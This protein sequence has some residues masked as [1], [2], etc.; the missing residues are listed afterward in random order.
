MVEPK[1]PL[2]IAATALLHERGD[3]F[4]RCRDK[5]V[6]SFD[7]EEIHD[8][9]VASR[10]LREGLQLFL[11]CYHGKLMGPLV[12]AFRKVT[13]L[14][15]EIRNTDEAASFFDGLMPE[16]DRICQHDVERLML[17]FRKKRQKELSRLRS[18]LLSLA[19]DSLRDRYRHAVNAL[20]LFSTPPNAVDLF[21]PLAEFAATALQDR[22]AKVLELAPKAAFCDAIEAQHQLRIA[23]KH[24]RYRV[25]ILSVLFGTE[26]EQLHGLMKRYQ[27]VLG[28]MH[29]LDVFAAIV[30]AAG[31]TPVAEELVVAAITNRRSQWFEKFSRMLKTEPIGSIGERAR[32][33]W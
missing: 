18:G 25:E 32:S 2:W 21:A 6:K 20:P 23:V 14:L 4:F 16:V 12:K 9:R 5:V 3:E 29:D 31:F 7:P 10:R 19:S 26:F 24:L 33:A 13:R 8:L 17:S 22:T 28:K 11:P 1:T 27:E 30:R 15:G